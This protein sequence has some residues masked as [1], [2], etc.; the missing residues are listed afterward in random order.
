M[1]RRRRSPVS[2]GPPPR[3][4]GWTKQQRQ[5]VFLD[6]LERRRSSLDAFMWQAPA[7]TVAAQAFLLS[8]LTD[9]TVSHVTLEWV[10][11]AG[12]AASAAAIIA[13]LRLR[14]REVLYSEAIAHYFDEQGI[15]DPRPRALKRTLRGKEGK[16]RWFHLWDWL[17]KGAR[18][19]FGTNLLPFSYWVWVAALALFIVADV[20]AYKH[21]IHHASLR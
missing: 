13:L 16:P 8:V 18:R 3:N 14:S 4:E 15:G 10:L 11:Y 21:T 7:L 17:D 19:F 5:A 6:H 1:I 9:T 12:V 20:V 2:S